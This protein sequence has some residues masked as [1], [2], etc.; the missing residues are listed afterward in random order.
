MRNVLHDH[1]DVD[2]LVGHG[3]EDAR[4]HAR[5][6]GHALDRDLGLVVVV[7]HA[8]DEGLFHPFVF[9]PNPCPVLVGKGGPDVEHHTGVP[10]VLHGPQLEDL[11]AGRGELQHL[12]VGH[13]V[14]LAG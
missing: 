7:H 10:S 8:G 13:G 14:E 6:V 2:P 12:L 1:V 4:G 9:L 11:R 3:A 5:A